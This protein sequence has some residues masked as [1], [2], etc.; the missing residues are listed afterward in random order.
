MKLTKS[1]VIFIGTLTTL[2]SYSKYLGPNFER[3][4]LN[5]G[6]IFFKYFETLV[7]NPRT[8]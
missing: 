6:Y 2:I 4:Q 8:R 7:I 3:A 5:I 1:I